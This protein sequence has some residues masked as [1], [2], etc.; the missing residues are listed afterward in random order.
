MDFILHQ[1]KKY[2]F[3]Q[4]TN[5]DNQV[6]SDKIEY[7]SEKSFK[8]VQIVEEEDAYLHVVMSKIPVKICEKDDNF[9]YLEQYAF[10]HSKSEFCSLC[11]THETQSYENTE[12]QWNNLPQTKS[13]VRIRNNNKKY[14]EI[15]SKGK[16]LYIIINN[17]NI[18]D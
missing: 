10:K 13:L 2:F 3:K 1:L 5:G 4:T 12:V 15:V 6:Y 9:A 11:I 7:Y 8:V 16:E 14:S 18:I 17:S